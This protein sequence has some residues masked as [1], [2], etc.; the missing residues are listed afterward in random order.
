MTR[1][2]FYV[3]SKTVFSGNEYVQ[4]TFQPVTSGSP[5][6]DN[7]FK[8]TP[9]GKLEMSIKPE[10]AELF[11]VGKSYYLDFSPAIVQAVETA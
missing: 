7:F 1:A 5:E 8:W 3:Y 2:K 10:V 6:N 11:E 4:V 9:S